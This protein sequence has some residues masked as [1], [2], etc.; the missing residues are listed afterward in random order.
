M[1]HTV[2][3]YTLQQIEN[4][5]F[6][7]DKEVNRCLDRSK[8]A[9]RLWKETTL[10]TELATLITCEMGK[11]IT[12]AINE[13]EK[14]VKLC[15]YYAEVS[16]EVLR[17]KNVV[18]EYRSSYVS[19]QPLGTILGIMPWNYPFWQVFRYAIPCLIAGNCTILKH[20]PNVEGCAIQI[21]EIF[22]QILPVKDA[23]LSCR[24]TNSQVAKAIASDT[25][26]GVTLTGSER[27]GSA[28][29]TIAGKYIKKTVL[30]LGGM[31]AF[32]IHKDANLEEA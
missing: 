14:C 19:Y 22:H 6:Y 20:A 17:P 16:E 18:T 12:Q 7:S 23:F 25:I 3:P 26:Q 31:D 30:E 27:A 1:Y 29:A 9:Y 8:G 10:S 15:E 24:M 2:N 32:M 13:I 28:V 21:A 4:Y 11:P 5:S